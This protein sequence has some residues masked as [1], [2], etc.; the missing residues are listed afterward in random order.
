MR[1]PP[2]GQPGRLVIRG[3]HVPSRRSRRSHTGC[4][5]NVV[6]VRQYLVNDQVNMA[7]DRLVM[8][9]DVIDDGMVTGIHLISFLVVDEPHVT[10]R[11]M[12]AGSA[13]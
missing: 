4:V 13:E 1:T 9:N 2:R 10:A 5:E 12:N 3:F 6:E 8:G 7:H 11:R